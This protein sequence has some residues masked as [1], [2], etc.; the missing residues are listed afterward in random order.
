MEKRSFAGGAHPHENKDKTAG[1]AI[2]T[3]PVPAKVVIPLSQHVGA[4]CEPLVKAGDTVALGQKI[5]DS[6]AFVSAPVHASVSG[7]VVAIEPYPAPGGANVLS[8]IIESDGLDTV[9]DG[10]KP[11]GDLAGLSAADLKSAIHAAGIVGM[12]GAGFPTHV[13]LSPPPDKKVD[14]YIINAAECEPYVTADHRLMLEQPQDVVLG[15]KALMKAAGIEQGFI[16]IED[17]KPDAIEAM[18]HAVE[19]EPTIR[20]VALTTKYPQGGEKQLIEAVT[21]R[22]VPS[23]GLPADV[24][25]LVSNV[26]TAIAVATLLKTGMP[27]IERVTTVTGPLVKEPKNLRIRVGTLFSELI[28]DCGGLTG[29]AAKVINGGPM[30]GIAQP[31]ADVPA[32]K[33]TSCILVLGEKDLDKTPARA[34]IRCG[35]CVDACPLRLMPITISQ[36]AER[37]MYDEA[38]KANALDCCECGTCAYVCPSRRPLVEAIRVAKRVAL[39]KRK[40]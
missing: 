16:A 19:N 31:T 37:G 26:G 17:N 34:C 1:L 28:E 24:G 10:I 30:M 8:V 5:G 2:V 13:K 25:V 35:R 15:F 9:A 39:A 6:S 14:T 11:L 3:A 23:G 21:K 22:Q 32:A 20:I 36:Y 29:P 38:A 7:K 27:V 33:G 4:P 18:L 12:G 40:K